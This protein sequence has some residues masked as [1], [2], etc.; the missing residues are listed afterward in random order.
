MNSV[1]IERYLLAGRAQAVFAEYRR[2]ACAYWSATPADDRTG[3][4]RS[5]PLGQSRP[6]TVLSDQLRGQLNAL[7]PEVSAYARRVGAPTTAL[8]TGVRSGAVGN[9]LLGVFQPDQG[10]IH[11]SQQEVVDNLDRCDG[12]ARFMR[13]EAGRQLWYPWTWLVTIVAFVLRLP[14]AILKGAGLPASIE[15]SA[16]AGVIK[17]ILLVVLT[18]LAG[19]LGIKHLDASALGG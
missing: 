12:A 11:I 19:Y 2:L 10:M 5:W 8:G 3:I 7:L 14:F 9:Y 1:P 4:A 15:E 17:V 18:L 13:R 16:W 6:E